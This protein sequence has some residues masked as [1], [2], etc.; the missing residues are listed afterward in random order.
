MPSKVSNPAL[1]ATICDLEHQA[2]KALCTSGSALLPLLSSNP[3]MI[4]PGDMIFTA[5]SSPTLHDMMKD[6][7]FQPWKS[8]KLSH[9]EASK[10][11]TL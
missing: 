6:P 8:Y 4:F 9:D 10:A 1:T 2:W 3:V 11:L 7:S 5:T